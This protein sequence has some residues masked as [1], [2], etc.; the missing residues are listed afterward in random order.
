MAFIG[1]SVIVSNRLTGRLQGI[2]TLIVSFLLLIGAF[3]ALIIAFVELLIM[4]S[5]FLAPPFGTI[6]YLA[7]WGFFP[8]GDAAILLSL[9]LLLKIG[10]AIFLLLAQQQ[11]LKQKLL[12]AMI[13][14]TLL[15]T[16]IVSFLHGFVPIIL[17]SITDDIAAIVIA[18]V[19]I[20]WAI[21]VLVGAIIAVVKAIRTITAVE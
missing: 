5:L 7:I 13:L 21:I 18:I 1:L 12:I 16:V 19:A 3:I 11:F 15:L 10:F 4:V 14:T 2:V 17:V 20:V 9:V 8:R 6:A